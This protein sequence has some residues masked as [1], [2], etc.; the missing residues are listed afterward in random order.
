MLALIIGTK[1]LYA[2]HKIKL[3]FAIDETGGYVTRPF[4]VS[5]QTQV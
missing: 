2:D 1:F 5:A 3:M 4:S